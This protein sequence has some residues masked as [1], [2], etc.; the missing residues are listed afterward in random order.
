[1]PNPNGW[2][3]KRTNT[4]AV[5]A[6]KAK[7]NSAA[8]KAARAHVKILVASGRAYCWRPNCGKQLQPGHWHVGHDDLDPNRIRGG[9]CAS[10][11]LKA[12]A[13]KGALITNAR[14]KA[15]AFVRPTR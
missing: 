13:R 14:R 8:H 10:C 4:P 2:H 12:G 3:R 7:Y 9:E 11:N 15:A 1:M 6:R 5:A